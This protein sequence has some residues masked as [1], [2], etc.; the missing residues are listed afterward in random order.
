MKDTEAILNLDEI[1]FLDPTEE[2]ELEEKD[3][4]RIKQNPEL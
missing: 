3:M 2:K 1:P 4:E